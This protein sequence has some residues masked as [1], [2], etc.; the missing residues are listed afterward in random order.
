MGVDPRVANNLL[1]E[2][3]MG[4]CEWAVQVV[5][6]HQAVVIPVAMDVRTTFHPVIQVNISSTVA[7]TVAH[8]RVQRG[9]GSVNSL[10][11][12]ARPVLRVRDPPI[13]PLGR[14]ILRCRCRNKWAKV[15]ILVLIVTTGH[16]TTMDRQGHHRACSPRQI[17]VIPL[18]LIRTLRLHRRTDIRQTVSVLNLCFFLLII[19]TEV[20]LLA[21]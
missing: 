20:S 2:T 10:K 15:V 1:Q 14:R 7:G 17:L 8:R 11:E 12:W 13:I 5:M 19:S 18:V 16:Q 21:P 9:R 6:D 3:I 4:R